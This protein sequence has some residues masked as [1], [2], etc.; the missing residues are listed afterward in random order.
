MCDARSRLQLIRGLYH[1]VVAT[2][3][4]LMPKK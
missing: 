3:I 2:A 4:A 1:N